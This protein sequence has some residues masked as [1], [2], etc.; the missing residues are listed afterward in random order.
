VV[1]NHLAKKELEENKL[2]GR[3]IYSFL[4]NVDSSLLREGDE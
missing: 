2:Y 1:L 3:I 4:N